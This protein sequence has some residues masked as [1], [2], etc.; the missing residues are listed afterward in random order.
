[1]RSL[2]IE[3][4]HKS[5]NYDVIKVHPK[6]NRHVR[7]TSQTCRRDATVTFWK[8]DGDETNTLGKRNE[9]AEASGNGDVTK[10]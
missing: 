1:M 9:E 7:N 10:T 4:I 2:S 8:R 6:L 3:K 5:H